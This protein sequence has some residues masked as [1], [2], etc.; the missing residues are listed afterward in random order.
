MDTRVPKPEGAPAKFVEDMVLTA[1]FQTTTAPLPPPREHTK[2]HRSSH[3]S[4]GEG[5]R[6]SKRETLEM[7]APRRTLLLDEKDR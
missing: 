2:R 1:L 5:D 4:E 6:A 3:T 7:E